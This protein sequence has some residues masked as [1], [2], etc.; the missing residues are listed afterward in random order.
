MLA[1]NP[2]KQKNG[3]LRLLAFIVLAIGVGGAVYFLFFFDKDKIK[4]QQATRL[5]DQ[6]LQEQPEDLF[7]KVPREKI[8]D[9]DRLSED[10]N[11]KKIIDE[12]KQRFGFD[13]GVDAIVRADESLKVGDSIIPM[14]EILEKVRISKGGIIEES[15]AEKSAKENIDTFGIYIV[16][17]SD[18]LWN[19]HF[20][21]L[22]NYFER[23]NIHLTPMADKPDE[24]GM[25]SGVAKILK[26]SENIVSIYNV[27]DRKVYVDLNLLYPQNE[28]VVFHMEEI[29]SL[30]DQIDLQN[31]DNIRF[32]GQ[33]LWIPAKS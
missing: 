25:S 8:I 13:E 2:K 26:F 31:V 27:R 32:D 30:L 12:R 23:K 16:K 10:G 11:L 33:N 14:K 7:Q 29:F 9:F 20:R 18:N 19:I 6:K 17:P 21:F 4:S 24:R 28:I 3:S 5:P 1:E 22:R 15:L